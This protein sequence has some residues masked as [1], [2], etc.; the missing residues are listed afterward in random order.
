MAHSGLTAKTPAVMPYSSFS[1]HSQPISQPLGSAFKGSSVSPGLS[2]LHHV[3]FLLH[4]ILLT[5]LPAPTLAPWKPAQTM[6]LHWPQ[7]S[8]HTLNKIQSPSVTS[9]PFVIWPLPSWVTPLLPPL[10]AVCVLLP[11]LKRPH[12][13]LPFL[14]AGLGF[15][16]TCSRK[17][18]LTSP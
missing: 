7:A 16:A 8:P 11:S 15:T 13:R 18:S 3:F 2:Q 10:R 9:A 12:A 14:V 1:S 6:A 4:C 17:P 5:C